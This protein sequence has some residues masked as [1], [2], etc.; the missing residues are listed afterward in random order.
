MTTEHNQSESDTGG[1]NLA[2]VDDADNVIRNH[3]LGWQCRLRQNS[4]RNLNGQPS[5]GM[6]PDIVVGGSDTGYEGVTVL[7]TRLDP[8]E[9]TPEFRHMVRK[10]SDPKQRYDNALKYFA[11]MYYQD[12]KAFSDRMTA[13]FRPGSTAATRLHD[14]GTSTLAFSEKN[15]RYV[16]PCQVIRLADTDPSWQAT[17]WHNHLFNPTLAG[18]SIILQFV[19]DWRT[20]KAEPPVY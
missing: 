16:I 1:E 13:L 5:E 3:F 2:P 9:F 12:R 7:L 19:P 18:D 11:E 17:Y 4:I 10:T 6:S 15:Q 14:A 8:G 20:A